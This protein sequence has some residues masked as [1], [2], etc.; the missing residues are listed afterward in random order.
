MLKNRLLM[1]RATIH[2]KLHF[3]FGLLI[4]F[5]LPFAKL[6]PIIIALLLLNWIVEGRF[7][8]KLKRIINNKLSLLFIAVYVIH[9]IGLL[10][11]NNMD[12]GWFD[13]QVKLSL[14]IFPL[15]ISSK[16]YDKEQTDQIFIAFIVGLIYASIY[17]L[18]RSISLYLFNDLNAFFYQDFSTFIHTSYMAMYINM[19]V[20]WLL[21]K[22]FN[23]NNGKKYFSV[24]IMVLMIVFLSF[25]IFMLASKNGILV[26]LMISFGLIGYY[27]FFRKKYLIGII[28]LII[29]VSGFLAI[30]QF[31][32]G[33]QN[34]LNN[35]ISALTTKNTNKTVNSTANRLLIWESANHVINNNFI[36][37][38]GTG[39][40][41][42]ALCEEYEKR[43]F[44]NALEH[45]LNAHNEFYQ[46]FIAL[47]LIGGILL[48]LNLIYPFVFSIK[49]KNFLY[50]VFLIIIIV[51]FFSESMLETKAGVMFYALFNALLCF[52]EHE[53][54]HQKI[55][56]SD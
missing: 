29:I 11:T 4:A 46:I 28:G 14:L 40:A 50:S 13:L 12:S 30:K 52:S 49:T 56:Q 8:E 15:I 27:V 35:L 41:K 37:G 33:V 10:Y 42:E 17:M 2:N 53:I 48:C 6:T 9:I 22:I 36:I 16:P 7:I 55:N 34:R 18:S 23:K 19:A 44:E 43:G 5:T 39:D 25:I 20:C 54:K 47:G 31:V 24:P 26:L 3:V 21:F 45:Q 51:N 32:P 1:S 38:V